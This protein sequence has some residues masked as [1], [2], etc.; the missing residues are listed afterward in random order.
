M[1]RTLRTC[2]AALVTSAA[3]AFTALAEAKPSN[4]WRVEFDGGADS[5]G[6]IVL[7]I[8]PQG[9]MPLDATIAIT[10]GTGENSVAKAVVKAL[11]EQL[12]EDGFHV[13][14]DDGEDVLIKKKRGSADF[15]LEV[16]SNTVK[17]VDID[18]D[19]E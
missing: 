8:T 10:D 5:D 17:G 1:A 6:T 12:P 19:R 16:V 15:D 11:Q 4:K 9:G 7:R 3:I 18:L 2:A 13:E 14:R